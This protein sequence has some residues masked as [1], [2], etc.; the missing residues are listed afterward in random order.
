MITT[1]ELKAPVKKRNKPSTVPLEIDKT[2]K[3]FLSKTPASSKPLDVERS[4]FQTTKYLFN[5]KT[6]IK[7]LVTYACKIT[8]DDFYAIFT[9]RL[10]VEDL[11]ISDLYRK[12]DN[13]CSS[14]TSSRDRSIIT[15][16]AHHSASYKEKGQTYLST[17]SARYKK[18]TDADL[19][20]LVA[21]YLGWRNNR[22][23]T[24]PTVTDPVFW[25]NEIYIYKAGFADFVEMEISSDLHS[26]LRTNQLKE[27]IMWAFS[28]WKPK[29]AFITKCLGRYPNKSAVHDI[30]DL[31]KII[32]VVVKS[33]RRFNLTQRL[34]KTLLN[35]VKQFQSVELAEYKE[36]S[37]SEI[38]NSYI[39]IDKLLSLSPAR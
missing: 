9:H 10:D 21:A 30:T 3:L 19:K 11:T 36:D 25:D 23:V 8:P 37:S 4:K 16:S 2:I 24:L 34:D 22:T 33:K 12:L 1:T 17:V 32:S 14:I 6:G 27:M 29:T 38:S 18:I 35:T 39:H 15:R 13:M 26:K 5:S 20:Y 7:G 31:Y 28:G